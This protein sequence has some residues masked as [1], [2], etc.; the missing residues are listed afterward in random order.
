MVIRLS[1]VKPAV[2]FRDGWY[3]WD[4]LNAI[5]ALFMIALK[6]ATPLHK[7][8]GFDLR[9]ICFKIWPGIE[10]LI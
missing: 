2:Y 8:R 6:I 10:I 3:I 5:V 9:P 4:F 7:L 1:A